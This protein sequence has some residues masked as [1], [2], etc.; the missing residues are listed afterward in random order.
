LEIDRR[1]AGIPP[2]P[3]SSSLFLRLSPFSCA[4]TF[5]LDSTWNFCRGD[6][7]FFS[8]LSRESPFLR[9]VKLFFLSKSRGSSSHWE[10]EKIPPESKEAS[11]FLSHRS[12]LP[13]FS[14]NDGD[15]ESRLRA[16]SPLQ[17]SGFSLLS[18]RKD[19][20]LSN[21][22]LFLWRDK[23]LREVPPPPPHWDASSPPFLKN[24]PPLEFP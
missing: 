5:L 16:F 2:L 4:P 3:P 24:L 6:E 10:Q 13:F 20:P 8:F 23:P 21:H 14:L 1:G 11:A 7:A 9:P 19:F 12:F 22:W 17:S 15:C 18:Q